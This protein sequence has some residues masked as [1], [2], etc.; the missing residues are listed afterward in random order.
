MNMS[1]MIKQSAIQSL[2]WNVDIFPTSLFNEMPDLSLWN[3]KESGTTQIDINISL[4]GNNTQS[5]T[6]VSYSSEQ[7]SELEKEARQL[8]ETYVKAV[9]EVFSKASH[10]STPTTEKSHESGSTETEGK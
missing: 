10:G 4:F 9:E 6:S 3:P 7:D 5:T 2:P 8:T 1:Q